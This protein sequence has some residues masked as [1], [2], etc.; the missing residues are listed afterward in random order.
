[1]SEW[2]NVTLYTYFI[3]LVLAIYGSGL[4]FWWWAKKRSASAVFA[5]VSFLF[6]GEIVEVS[7]SL[8]AR[9]LLIASREEYTTFLLGPYWPFRKI[10]TLIAFICIIIHMSHRAFGNPVYRRRKDDT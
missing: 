10:V 4:F 6:V 8:Y 2:E 5:Y 9:Y 3:N 1:M 7:M